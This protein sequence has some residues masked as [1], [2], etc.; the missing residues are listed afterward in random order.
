MTTPESDLLDDGRPRALRWVAWLAF[1]GL[2]IWKSQT[3]SFGGLEFLA[4]A[5]TIG[6]SIFCVAKPLGG[7]KVDLSEPAHV[8]GGFVSR[9]NCCCPG[10]CCSGTT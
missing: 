9:T 8:L 5:L 4:L 1:L 6:I 3:V 10:Y 2:A 7:P